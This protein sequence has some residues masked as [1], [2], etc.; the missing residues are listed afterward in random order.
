MVLDPWQQTT[1]FSS[2][3]WLC[4]FF[5]SGLSM[6]LEVCSI[7]VHLTASSLFTQRH[8]SL[9]V[10]S[11]FVCTRHRW[12]LVH[13]NRRQSTTFPPTW[14]CSRCWWTCHDLCQRTPY[15]EAADSDAWCMDT[16]YSVPY[17][18]ND[19]FHTV[20]LPVN[21]LCINLSEYRS[22][23]QNL[24]SKVYYNDGRATTMLL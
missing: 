8:I 12:C 9:S 14:Q 21:I 1:T 23:N 16:M 22:V 4:G 13:D 17:K 10:V 15:P 20:H 5:I 6:F 3:W 2:G 18:N 7:A 19:M 24:Q 11:F